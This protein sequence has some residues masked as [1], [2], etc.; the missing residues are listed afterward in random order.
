MFGLFKSKE[1]KEF[2][3][4]QLKETQVKI[5]E[6]AAR[7][8]GITNEVIMEAQ[9]KIASQPFFEKMTLAQASEQLLNTLFT[10]EEIKDAANLYESAQK[11]HMLF[12]KPKSGKEREESQK[13][14]NAFCKNIFN[15]M[16]LLFGGAECCN[17]V[18][19]LGVE[20]YRKQAGLL[21]EKLQIKEVGSIEG[22]G[23]CPARS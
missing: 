2:E 10:S 15:G 1:Q 17:Q 22:V 3:Q 7:T 18:D 12:G 21:L 5:L 6:I 13:R 14:L 9:K 19:N 11:V 8:K 4:A 23:G 20:E 16:H